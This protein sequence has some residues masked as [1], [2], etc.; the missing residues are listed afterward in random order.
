MLTGLGGC[1]FPP[2][3]AR[4][5]RLDVISDFTVSEGPVVLSLFDQEGIGFICSTRFVPLSVGFDL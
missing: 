5:F 2:V 4:M 3:P 1:R